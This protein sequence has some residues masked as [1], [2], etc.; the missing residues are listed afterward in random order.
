M[1]DWD[2]RAFWNGMIIS[3]LLGRPHHM[4]RFLVHYRTRLAIAEAIRIK[5]N[6]YTLDSIEYEQH[7]SAGLTVYF[8]HRMDNHSVHDITLVLYHHCP[9]Y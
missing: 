8:V 9:G 4:E 6:I 1:V 5:R 2:M 7:A 3:R